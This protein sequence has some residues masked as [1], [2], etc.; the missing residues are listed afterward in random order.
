MIS[1]YTVTNWVI[2]R[3]LHP[4]HP[5]IRLEIHRELTSFQDLCNLSFSF[6]NSSGFIRPTHLPGKTFAK[7]SAWIHVSAVI[8]RYNS[9]GFLT[10]SLMKQLNA[11]WLNWLIFIPIIFVFGSI[12]WIW[13]V[14]RPKEVTDKRWN[15]WGSVFSTKASLTDNTTAAIQFYHLNF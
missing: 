8:L 5:I 13:N 6:N 7:S 12:N 9:T 4:A 3:H 2:L 10:S 11:T 15:I 14:M 1:V